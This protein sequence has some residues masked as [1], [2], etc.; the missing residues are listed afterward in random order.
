MI[1][2]YGS[3]DKVQQVVPTIE[4]TGALFRLGSKIEINK[5][6]YRVE[7]AITT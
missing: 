3:H 6:R 1:Q 4:P 2:V 5:E 7:P